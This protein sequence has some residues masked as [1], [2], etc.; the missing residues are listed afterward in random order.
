MAVAVGLAV[1]GLASIYSATNATHP[2]IYTKGTY[3][4][5]MGVSVMLIAAILDYT[6]LNHFAYI[7][8]GLSMMLLVAVL[9]LG[10][11]ETNRWL[12]LGVFNVQ[13]SE[14]AKL[15]LIIILAKYFSDRPS[16]KEGLGF[17]DLL[18]PG[19]I[20]VVPFLLVAKEPDLGTAMVLALIF[21]SITLTI[22]VKPRVIIGLT[23]MA[24]AV[25][26][27]AWKGL[28][29]YQKARLLSFIMPGADPHGSGYHVM[30]SKIAIG[31]GGFFGK[32]FL[33]G[34]QGKLLFLPEHYTDFIFS[35]FAEEWGL[36]GAM[37]VLTLFFVLILRGLNTAENSRDRFG[38]LLSL[39]ISA[40]FF[41]HIIINL[42]MVSGLMPVV[43]VPL[44]FIS[45]GGSF[46]L[47][48]MAAIGI[49]LSIR[50]RRFVS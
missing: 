18:I 34:T 33:K 24:A 8:Y 1:I 45:Y 28:K 48:S 41:W 30:Q 17:R 27:F 20:M 22:K 42:G 12:D 50:M 25:F 31:S 6:L 5:I 29:T 37:V 44:P 39:G 35:V 46:M 14:I 40:M 16:R 15:A 47:T 26:P 19:L 32:G 43:G 11:G 23:L 38:F 49:L 2:E 13:P 4:I 9:F 3:W 21:A 10:H 7:I 36:L